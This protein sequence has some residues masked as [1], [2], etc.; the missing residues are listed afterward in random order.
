MSEHE[1]PV[2]RVKHEG[3]EDGVLINASDFVVGEHELF[4][5]PSRRNKPKPTYGKGQ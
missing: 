1:V 4:D 2:L 5:E 3:F